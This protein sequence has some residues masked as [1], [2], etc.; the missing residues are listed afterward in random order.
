VGAITAI[1]TLVTNKPY[2]GWQR[3]TWDPM[4]LGALLIGVPL[5]I[6]RWLAKG[7]GGIRH[8]F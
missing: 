6:R 2:L 5:L 4:L 7:P 8:D 1:L 3:H